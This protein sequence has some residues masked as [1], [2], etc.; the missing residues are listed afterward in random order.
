MCKMK[1]VKQEKNQIMKNL[2]DH[3]KDFEFY[4]KCNKQLVMGNPLKSFKQ[5]NDMLLLNG[6]VMCF[7]WVSGGK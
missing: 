3:C 6:Q 5:R 4:P 2:V 7:V 1:L